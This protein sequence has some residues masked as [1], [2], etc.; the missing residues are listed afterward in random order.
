MIDATVITAFILR[1]LG[2]SRYMDIVNNCYTVEHAV[3]EVSNAIWK[4]PVRGFIS[5]EKLFT[6]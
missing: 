3:K 2:W 5:E 4:Y 6:I 1:E